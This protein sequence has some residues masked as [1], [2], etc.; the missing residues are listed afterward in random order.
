MPDHVHFLLHLLNG[1]ERPGSVITAVGNFK[2]RIS[3]LWR[4]WYT[5]TFDQS[6]PEHLWQ[7]SFYDIIMRDER[8]LEN[9]RQYIRD[10]PIKLLTAQDDEAEDRLN[11]IATKRVKPIVPWY[12]RR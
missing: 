8:Q 5:K 2:G 6:A 12:E 4:E 11:M 1:E 10:N 3:K 7:L 9:T